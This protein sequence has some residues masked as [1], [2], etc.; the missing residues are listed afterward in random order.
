MS[1]LTSVLLEDPQRIAGSLNQAVRRLRSSQGE[2]QWSAALLDGTVGFCDRAAVFTVNDGIL[3]LARVRNIQTSG[4]LDDVPLASAPAFAAA[5]D[6]RDTV[7]AIRTPGEMSPSLASSF[8]ESETHKF[9]LFPVTARGRV[10]RL[11]YADGDE[12]KMDCNCLE[13][14]AAVAGAVIESR[15]HPGLVGIAAPLSSDRGER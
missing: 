3:R 9:R 2:Q 5:V 11:L 6:S 12:T 15:A 10:S 4:P 1:D 8:G 7:V 14:L 13:L